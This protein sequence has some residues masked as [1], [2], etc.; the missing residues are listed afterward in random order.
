M[1][2][3][4]Q[5]HLILSH[6]HAQEQET[7]EPERFQDGVDVALALSMSVEGFL[8]AV[9][10]LRDAGLLES[11]ASLVEIRLTAAGRAHLDVPSEAEECTGES[12][13]G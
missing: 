6:L 5:Q 12:S 3:T 13:E 8:R 10:D 4:Q 7:T 1:A 9:Q 2:V 11:A